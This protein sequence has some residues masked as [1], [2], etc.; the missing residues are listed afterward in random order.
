MTAEPVV[1]P[2]PTARP[3]LAL[4]LDVDDLD[5]A[6]ALATSLRDWFGVAKV[7][8]ELYSAA[9]PAA[10]EAMRGLGYAVFADLKLHDIPTTVARAARV[11]GRLGATYLTMHAAGGEVMVRAGVDGFAAGARDRGLP[12]PIALGVT[13]LT[14]EPDARA[15]D[16]RLAVA[17][18]A[19][20][21]GVVCS[22][23]E[24]ARVRSTAPRLVT[25]V[26]GVRLAGDDAHDQARV[27]TPAEVATLGAD[28]LVIGRTVTA[29]ADPIAAAARVHAELAGAVSG[30]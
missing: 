18:R 4:V 17:D 14:S 6:I 3:R 21:G 9:G 23:H 5:R 19:G 22:A 29:A 30:T 2:D 7:G 16:E 10:I 15:F 12:D 13:V 26:P 8:L 20:C 1:Q 28:V 24:V 27:A 11:V 25:V